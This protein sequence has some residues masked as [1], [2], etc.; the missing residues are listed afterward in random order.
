MALTRRVRS[1]LACSH[2]RSPSGCGRRTRP[3]HRQV[4]DTPGY[5]GN[6]NVAFMSHTEFGENSLG[7]VVYA[8]RWESYQQM[9]DGWSKFLADPEWQR[10]KAD[11]ERDGP[12]NG[13]VRRRL[14]NTAPFDA[15]REA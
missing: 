1:G 15:G 12:L 7:E 11:S 10:V 9:Q 8:V 5:R 14:L 2:R 13:A 4:A 3:G 6:L